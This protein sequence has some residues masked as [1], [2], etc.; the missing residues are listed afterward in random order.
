MPETESLRQPGFSDV[1]SDKLFIRFKEFIEAELG[2]RMPDAKKTMLQAR[3]QKRLRKLSI[4]TFEDYYA[5]V[6]SQKGKESELHHMIDVVTTNKTDFFREPG[7]FE[8]LSQKVLPNMVYG[9]KDSVKRVNVWSAGCATG[10]EPY[11]LAMVLS[12]FA[13]KCQEFNF[14]VIG[15]DISTHVLTKAETGIYDEERIE[16][17]PHLMRK[18]YLLKSKDKTKRLIRIAPEIRKHTRFL[19]LNLMDSHYNLPEFMDIIFFRNVLIYF[20]RETQE[21]V[22]NQMSRHLTHGGYLFVGHSETLSG[23]KIP[24]VQ[25]SATVYRKV[26]G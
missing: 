21:K 25:E 8:Y 22:L 11:T 7:H 16:P 9:R 17:I 14:L 18:K 4:S 23:L 24:F 13:L 19:R 6:F 1:M 20:K 2:I 15:T 10:E 26:R 5:Y 12:D 3:L